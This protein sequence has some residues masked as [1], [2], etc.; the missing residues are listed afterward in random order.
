M[1]RAR[2]A[3]S[4][5]ETDDVHA[6]P[7]STKTADAAPAAVR[8][9]G[10]RRI[11]RSAAEKSAK[12]IGDFAARNASRPIARP[13]KWASAKAFMELAAQDA[14]QPAKL[15]EAQMNLWWDYMSLWQSSML[16]HAGRAPAEPSPAAKGD[17]RFKHELAGALPV[18]L[19]QA[20]VP[21][22]RALAARQVAS[23]EGCPSR[24]ARRST[25]SRASTST[26][27]RRRTSR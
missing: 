26:R 16:Q 6:R 22:H 11:A 2:P 18:R 21:D 12:L 17:K 24:R 15:A 4:F 3:R 19:R 13:T 1:T 23:V 14:R 10:A 25:S 27:W 9:G 7:A 8:P 20:V 5:L